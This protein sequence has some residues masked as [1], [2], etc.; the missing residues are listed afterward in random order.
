MLFIVG[1]AIGLI[2][3]FSGIFDSTWIP[4]FI[5]L[6]IICILGLWM[7]ISYLI[8]LKTLDSQTYIVRH[9]D[10]TACVIYKDKF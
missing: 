7:F 9:V 4:F 2:A 8:P 6:P 1:L 3:L 5:T 10:N